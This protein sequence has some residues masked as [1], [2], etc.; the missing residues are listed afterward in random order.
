[1]KYRHFFVVSPVQNIQQVK[2]IKIDFRNNIIRERSIESNSEIIFL[3]CVLFWNSDIC[4]I[5]VSFRVSF[6][7]RFRVRYGV[8]FRVRF[9]VRFRFRSRVRLRVRFR[10]RLGLGLSLGLSLG[11]IHT[12]VTYK[13]HIYID[14]PTL[15][16]KECYLAVIITLYN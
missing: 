3:G 6:M 11:L 2:K 5:M 12:Y 10:V 7:V 4:R 15:K 8:R 9:K 13:K 1:M 14:L 16:V